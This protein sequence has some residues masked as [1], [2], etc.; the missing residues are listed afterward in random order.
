MDGLKA[1]GEIIVIAAT[2]QPDILDEALRRGGRFYR[3]IEIGVPDKKGRKEMLDIHTRGMPLAD[4][5]D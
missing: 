1:R 2:N 5:V 3:E 4:E